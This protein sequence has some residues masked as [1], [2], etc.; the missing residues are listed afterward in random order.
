MNYN[1][2]L[3]KADIKDELE[4]LERLE[5]EFLKVEKITYLSAIPL[6]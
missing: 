6:G 3:L 1:L 5:Q 2:E 4:K